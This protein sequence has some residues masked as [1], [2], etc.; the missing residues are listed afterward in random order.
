MR[1]YLEPTQLLLGHVFQVK[2]NS[3]W[4]VLSY[5]DAG[6]KNPTVR[7]FLRQYLESTQLLLGHVFQVKK[8]LQMACGIVC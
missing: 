6:E 5:A 4:L 2:N 3:R 8:Q 1:Q 7:Q